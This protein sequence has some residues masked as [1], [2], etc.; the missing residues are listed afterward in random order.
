LSN[1]INFDVTTDYF[2]T[3]RIQYALQEARM[4]F[5]YRTRQYN[6]ESTKLPFSMTVNSYG[7]I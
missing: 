6:L 4:L 3:R 7:K 1:V 2:S 5:Q